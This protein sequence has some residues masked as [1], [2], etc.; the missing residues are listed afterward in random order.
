MST[1]SPLDLAIQGNGW[2]RVAAHNGATFGEVLYS[3][4][5]SFHRDAQGKVATADGRYLI[6]YTLDSTGKPTSTETLIEI[7]ANGTSISVSADGVV[8]S[9]D[10]GGTTATIGAASLARFP[11]AGGL[12]PAGSGLYRAS[13]ASGPELAGIPGS[14]G[15]G[16]LAV[17]SL[18]SSNVD[19]ADSIIDSILGRH[20]FAASARTFT[21]ADEL[22]EE[23][24]RLGRR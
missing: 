12:E 15:I 13:G 17:G 20:A 8:R 2:F 19:L 11:D 10:A 21:S 4:A 3:R 1:G 14:G 23:I 22:L 16:P 7:P 9:T 6:G 5:G 18:E 24:V